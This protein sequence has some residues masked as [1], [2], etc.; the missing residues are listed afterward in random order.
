M[1]AT[2]DVQLFAN[3]QS[4]FLENDVLIGDTA[5][6]LVAGQGANLPSPAAGQY[7]LLTV[8]NLSNGDLEVM[9]CTSRTGDLLTVQRAQEGTTAIGFTAG[10]SVV[11]MRLTKGTL[12]KMI[13]KRYTS[14][15][16]GKFLRVQANGEVYPEIVLQGGGGGGTNEV[17][18]ERLK[19]ASWAVNQTVLT[20]PVND[21]PVYVKEDGTI[22]RMVIIAGP[23]TG[24]AVLDVR[25]SPTFAL[26]ATAGYSICGGNK[27]TIV[28]SRYASDILLTGWNTNVNAGD[29]LSFVLES[30]SGF[31]FITI[32]LYVLQD[33]GLVGDHDHIGFSKLAQAETHTA[34]KGTAEVELTITAGAVDL[35]PQLSN[36]FYLEL[37][38]NVTAFTLASGRDGQAISIAVKQD[39]VGSRTLA[40]SGAN[41]RIV[42][43]DLT[44][45]AGAFTHYSARWVTA[46]SVW[47]VA[48]A[49]GFV[50][51]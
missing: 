51:A 12:E 42:N 23:E 4:V 22:T 13:Q 33:T 18:I 45:D 3:N 29:V 19:G 5:L 16:A 27:P 47:L 8:Q 20:L 28:G 50:A 38:E 36:A 43:T 24:S 15:E 26:P 44:A 14:T 40:F 49:T 6:S 11:Q 39:V 35:N 34:G 17:S 21:V 32:V 25:N 9:A 2:T 10:N 30:V 48:G 41:L 31:E 37:T 46:D 7:F 1:V